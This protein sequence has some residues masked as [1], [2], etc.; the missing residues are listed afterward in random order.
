MAVKIKLDTKELDRLIEQARPKAAK[1]VET[2]GWAIAG[3][4]SRRAPRDTS[5]LANSLLSESGMTGETLFTL[6][7]GV[8]YGIY[9]ELGTSRM[10][11]QPFV[12]PAVESW[13]QKFI[14]ALQELFK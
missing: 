1:L 14:D 3:D 4:A 9:Q 5:A 13:K 7:D 11:A 12:V 6:S 8:E 10:A 2:Y